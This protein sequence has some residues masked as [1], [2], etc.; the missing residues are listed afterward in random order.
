MRPQQK[1]YHKVENPL[2]NNQEPQQKNKNRLGLL[3]G[4]VFLALCITM[5][6]MLALL[7]SDSHRIRYIVYSG[8]IRVS[9]DE[10]TAQLNRLVKEKSGGWIIPYRS[11]YFFP[12]QHLQKELQATFGFS[13]V[14]IDV[15]RKD[16]T[17]HVRITEQGA[18]YT[19]SYGQITYNVASDGKLLEL[20]PE[21]QPTGLFSF[22]IAEGTKDDSQK[23]VP[24]RLQ[25]LYTQ[26][27]DIKL[28]EYPIQRIEL[29]TEHSTDIK[30]FTDQKWYSYID[31]SRDVASQLQIIQSVFNEKI[32]G[33]D[34]EGNLQYI[35]ARIPERVFYK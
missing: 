34:S 7:R 13:D 26:I 9:S 21:G 18:A 10:I 35:D 25:A 30:L 12:S 1:I 20:V 33:T 16:R 3:I 5:I 14:T 27:R 29:Q 2:F 6:V 4:V 17:L 15:I 22:K 28:L 24:N 32:K 11:T 8:N 19:I 31:A 23:T